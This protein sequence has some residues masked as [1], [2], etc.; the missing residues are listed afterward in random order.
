VSRLATEDLGVRTLEVQSW[1]EIASWCTQKRKQKVGYQWGKPQTQDSLRYVDRRFLF[2][3]GP[4]LIPDVHVFPSC[5]LAMAASRTDPCERERRECGGGPVCRLAAA[6]RLPCAMFKVQVSPAKNVASCR[7]WGQSQLIGMKA[8]W[9]HTHVFAHVPHPPN[10]LTWSDDASL[11]DRETTKH[12]L[13][14]GEGGCFSLFHNRVW[15]RGSSVGV[16]TGYGM[17]G[18]VVLVPATVKFVS[19][20]LRPFQFWDPSRLL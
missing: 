19:T 6:G 4:P 14:G 16:E 3:R 17:E 2:R 10:I 1:R 20:L 15:S 11:A 18:A 13:R 5:S 8:M 7:S 12:G 9:T